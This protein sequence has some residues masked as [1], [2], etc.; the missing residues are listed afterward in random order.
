MCLN[1]TQYNNS[2]VKCATGLCCMT[3]LIFRTIIFPLCFRPSMKWQPLF[4]IASFRPF[5]TPSEIFTAGAC[6]SV[7]HVSGCF[8]FGYFLFC[9]TT[10]TFYNSQGENFITEIYTSQ[11]AIPY[12]NGLPLKLIQR[13]ASLYT[14]ISVLCNSHLQLNSSLHFYY[15][16]DK[17]LNPQRLLR[18]FCLKFSNVQQ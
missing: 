15:V 9:Q 4:N 17:I 16:K 8:M 6:V 12:I 10:C 2:E 3:Y 7:K 11:V 1:C 5:M 18:A 13:N 14:R